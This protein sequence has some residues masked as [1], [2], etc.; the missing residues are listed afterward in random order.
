MLYSNNFVGER[1]VPG[2]IIDTEYGPRFVPGK[3]LEV[4]G[5]VTFT[6]AQIV[7]TDKGAIQKTIL[8]LYSFSI[9]TVIFLIQTHYVKHYY[10]PKQDLNLSR[11]IYVMMRM[12][13]EHIQCKVFYYRQR[14]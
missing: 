13:N 11:Q 2:Q 14:N 9:C 4:D 12:V 6:P 7:Q 5:E 3:I 8:M 1:F 10:F